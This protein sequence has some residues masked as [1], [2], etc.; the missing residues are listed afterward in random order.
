MPK[1]ARA[2]VRRRRKPPPCSASIW[3]STGRNR[4]RRW[5]VQLP[6]SEMAFHRSHGLCRWGKKRREEPR[7]R[8]FVG[9][10][11]GGA[12]RLRV[13][14]WTARAGTRFGRSRWFAN[15]TVEKRGDESTRH[16]ELGNTW[17]ARQRLKRETTRSVVRSLARTCPSWRPDVDK[18]R[19][20]PEC[21]A[22]EP[23]RKKNQINR[24]EA[25]PARHTKGIRKKRKKTAGTSGIRY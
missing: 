6:P 23:T 24:V 8:R 3:S 5:D 13:I 16:L 1:G 19:K 22:L 18:T 21:D 17:P 7:K 20:R 15:E 2:P 4:R 25:T 10:T 11:L 14:F 9:K 12:S